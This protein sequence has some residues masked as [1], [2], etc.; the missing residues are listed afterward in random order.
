MVAWLRPRLALIGATRR[1]QLSQI[2]EAGV[3][4]R[5]GLAWEAWSLFA[6][7]NSFDTLMQA[8]MVAILSPIPKSPP[9]IFHKVIMQNF[10]LLSTKVD[11]M[12][13]VVFSCILLHS[14]F[15]FLGI[16]SIVHLFILVTRQLTMQGLRLESREEFFALLKPQVQTKMQTQELGAFENIKMRFELFCAEQATPIKLETSL[17][18]DVPQAAMQ[19]RSAAL[20]TSEAVMSL[21]PRSNT[22]STF[23]HIRDHVQTH[24]LQKWSL[25]HSD[26]GEVR[27]VTHTHTFLHRHFGSN[28]SGLGALAKEPEACPSVFRDGLAEVDSEHPMCLTIGHSAEFGADMLG[29]VQGLSLLAS[30]TS[31]LVRQ[32]F[33]TMGP[34]R[35]KVLKQHDVV[36]CSLC[37]WRTWISKVLNRWWGDNVVF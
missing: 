34:E 27:L 19:V 5:T 26:H 2:Q 37:L 17:Y 32:L 13:D 16:F 24:A 29:A 6:I 18:E 14:G 21:A 12:K 9:L 30:S 3:S 4:S 8:I 1:A 7:Y 10:P 36:V 33:L 35:R 23:G 15:L 20:L 25:P 11:F 28:Q 31:K 22:R